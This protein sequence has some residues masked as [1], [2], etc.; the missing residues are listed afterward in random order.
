MAVRFTG[1]SDQLRQLNVDE[2]DLAEPAA[3]GSRAGKKKG[4]GS[5]VVGGSCQVAHL[6]SVCLSVCL[7]V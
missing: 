1:D 3:A 4:G 6:L 5:E 7:S 2:D